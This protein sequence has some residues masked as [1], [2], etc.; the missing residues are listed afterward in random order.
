MKK[1]NFKTAENDLTWARDC[2]R[3]IKWFNNQRKQNI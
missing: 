1:K 3:W 2:C